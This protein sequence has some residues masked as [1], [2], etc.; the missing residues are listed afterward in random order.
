MRSGT[1]A[2][3]ALC[4]LLGAGGAQ[5][6]PEKAA[7][8]PGVIAGAVLDRASGSPVSKAL[9]TLS[10]GEAAPLDAQAITDGA[11]RFT[12]TAVP[13][14]RYHLHADCTGYRDAWYGAE[15]AN[16]PATIITLHAGE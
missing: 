12:F 16:H 7:S 10:T 13:P 8:E 2:R 4:L 5:C 14:G 11:G 1:R 15:T 9:V 3:V 6:Q